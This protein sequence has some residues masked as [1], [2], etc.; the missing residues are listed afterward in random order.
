MQI[1]GDKIPSVSGEKIC[2]LQFSVLIPIWSNC[3]LTSQ[4][5]YVTESIEEEL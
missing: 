5:R 3:I 4:Y 1:I 2:V